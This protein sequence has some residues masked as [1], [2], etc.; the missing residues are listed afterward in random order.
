MSRFE[1]KLDNYYTKKVIEKI[2]EKLYAFNLDEIFIEDCDMQGKE[3]I[4]IQVNL[5]GEKALKKPIHI[6]FFHK[7]DSI[8]L[9]FEK[10]FYD[11]VIKSVE[12]ELKKFSEE[13]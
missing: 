6:M 2:R 13:L 1:K 7:K 12:Y 4:D 11:A 5:R 10:S 9:L 3:L 8:K